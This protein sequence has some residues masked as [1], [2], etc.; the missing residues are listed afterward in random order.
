MQFVFEVGRTFVE[1]LDKRVLRWTK[2]P[3]LPGDLARLWRPREPCGINEAFVYGDVSRDSFENAVAILKNDS[4]E[5]PAVL[6]VHSNEGVKFLLGDHHLLT[7]TEGP[8]A[9]G[10]TGVC[11]G[12]RALAASFSSTSRPLPGHLNPPNIASPIANFHFPSWIM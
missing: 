10:I 6:R 5:F 2:E 3:D 1:V 9:F 7:A 11:G 4:S 12:R 8:F